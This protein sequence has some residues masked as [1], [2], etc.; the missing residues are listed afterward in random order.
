MYDCSDTGRGV[1]L[2]ALTAWGVGHSSR[3]VGCRAQLVWCG[4]GVGHSLCGV[5]QV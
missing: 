4:A 3:G 1:S 2:A 5:G